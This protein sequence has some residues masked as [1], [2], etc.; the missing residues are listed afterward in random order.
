M[1]RLYRDIAFSAL[2]VFATVISIISV[3]KQME[4]QSTGRR[5]SKYIFSD[6]KP[7]NIPE[8]VLARIR[9]EHR[10]QQSMVDSFY[11][12]NL[13]KSRMD[14][15]P[16]LD[17]H[18]LYK[19]EAKGYAEQEH[20]HNFDEFLGFVGTGGQN[21]PHEL[22]AELELWL[23]GEQ[24]KISKSCIIHVPAGVKHCPLRF[25]RIDT[26][27]LFF[28]GAMQTSY[29]R[30][31]TQ[32]VKDKADERHYA[33][34]ISYSANPQTTSTKTLDIWR[35]TSQK[36]SPVIETTRL[37]DTDGIDGALRIDF[38]WLWKGAANVPNHR[39]YSHDWGEAFGFIGSKVPEN[40]RELGGEIEFWI[41]GE[42]QYINK[43]SVIW[44]PPG[45][46]HSLMTVNRVHSPILM[47]TIGMTKK[48]D[49]QRSPAR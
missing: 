18:W 45:L 20:T 39:E 24:Y 27:V 25:S 35:E 12:V 37:M 15:A 1:P 28:T 2:L 36:C 47:F 38:V 9:A 33:K 19:G 16:Y 31:A 34:Y 6:V 13:D 3:S 4:G 32:F 7:M 14:G 5:Y 30:T 8:E 40:P 42:K 17:F 49:S 41:N 11:L 46:N 26:P 29:S 10:A 44:I 43:S 22:G 48:S 23:G 21:A